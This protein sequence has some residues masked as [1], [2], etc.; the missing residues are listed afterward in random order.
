MAKASALRN[1]TVAQL[2]KLLHAKKSQLTDLVVKRDKLKSELDG[3]NR[4]IAGLGG[5]AD[6]DTPRR[7]RPKGSVNK[8]KRK[9]GRKG[10]RPKNAMSLAKYIE[11]ELNNAKKGMTVEELMN[12]VSE[13]GYKS[14]SAK[15]RNVVYQCLFH[16]DQF[17]KDGD[18]ARWVLAQS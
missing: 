8:T 6:E 1:L 3:L 2:E 10:R 9:S 12:K 7:G 14:K 15:F 4:E 18:S 5:E 13:A 11:A 17:Q 16:R